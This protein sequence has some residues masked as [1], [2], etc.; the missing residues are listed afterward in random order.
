MNGSIARF[1]GSSKRREKTVTTTCSIYTSCSIHELEFT[2]KILFFPIKKVRKKII[3][4][5]D[6]RMKIYEDLVWIQTT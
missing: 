6:P 2:C 1:I 3:P 4:Q 5:R